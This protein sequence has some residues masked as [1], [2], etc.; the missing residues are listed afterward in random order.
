MGRHVY[1]AF[2]LLSGIVKPGRTDEWFI[3]DDF[4]EVM[5]ADFCHRRIG[6]SSF[7]QFTKDRWKICNFF[8]QHRRDFVPLGHDVV[9]QHV[10]RF[11]RIE[12]SLQR[13]MI[14]FF[15]DSSRFAL[16]SLPGFHSGNL[17]AFARR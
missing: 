16:N 3:A 13:F 1:N 10:L 2:A 6:R 14:Y 17:F 11:G 15:N 9:E 7:L 5:N 12:R 4:V 8:L